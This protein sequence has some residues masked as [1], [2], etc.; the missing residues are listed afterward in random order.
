M[1]FNL[2]TDEVWEDPTGLFPA[3]GMAGTM[4]L[5]QERTIAIVQEQEGSWSDHKVDRTRHLMKHVMG[6]EGAGH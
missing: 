5:R 4:A 2:R 1:T 6:R 3:V